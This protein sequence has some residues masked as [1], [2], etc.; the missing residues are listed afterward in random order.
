MPDVYQGTELWEYSLVDPD[1][2]RPVDFAARRALLARLDD[3]WLPDVDADG[4]AKLLVTLSGLRLRRDR[5]ELFAGYRP[6]RPRA[7]RR[8]H[9]VA[10][11]RSPS[12]WRSRPG[13]RWAWRAAAAGATPCSPCRAPPPTGTT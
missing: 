13:C 11:A 5:P 7:R 4:A 10:F 3:G 9:A 2:R 8:P 1:N 12:R 6:S